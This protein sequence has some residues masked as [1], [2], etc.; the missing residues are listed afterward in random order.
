M[1]V[2]N[3]TANDIKVVVSDK[4]TQFDCVFVQILAACLHELPREND[5]CS[6]TMLP[7]LQSDV[8]RDV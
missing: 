2:R 8:R 1:I 5:S 4:D 3:T 7:T 6:M